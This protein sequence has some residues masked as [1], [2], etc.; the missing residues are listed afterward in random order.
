[1]VRAYTRAAKGALENAAPTELIIYK[2]FRVVCDY[3]N[4]EK[5]KY[6]FEKIGVEILEISYTDICTLT[7]RVKEARVSQ[8]MQ[9]AGYSVSFDFFFTQH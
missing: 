8:F 1:L 9:G 3:K 7:V 4:F 6:D 2:N 5:V